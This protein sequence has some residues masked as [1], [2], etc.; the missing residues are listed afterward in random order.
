MAQV[1][2][3]KELQTFRIHL[4]PSWQTARKSGRADAG[5][6]QFMVERC[7]AL[8]KRTRATEENEES[9]WNKSTAF[10]A[11]SWSRMAMVK[12]QRMGDKD[13]EEGIQVQTER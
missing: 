1:S 11:W 13:D 2:F 4:Q 6:K 10:S 12:N 9:W 5:S 3:C 7:T 8:Q